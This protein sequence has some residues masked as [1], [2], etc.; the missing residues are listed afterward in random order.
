MDIIVQSELTENPFVIFKALGIY[1]LD[2]AYNVLESN[3]W[4]LMRTVGELLSG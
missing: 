2:L 1:N 3:K 4:N